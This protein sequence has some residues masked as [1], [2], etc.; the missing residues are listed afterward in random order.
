MLFQR[1]SESPSKKWSKSTL[2]L[3]AVNEELTNIYYYLIKVIFLD[4]K[5]LV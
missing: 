1:G 2:I 3:L 5:N 4:Y